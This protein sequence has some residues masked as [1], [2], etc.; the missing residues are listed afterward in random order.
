M[1]RLLQSLDAAWMHTIIGDRAN[2]SRHDLSSLIETHGFSPTPK[3]TQ[4]RYRLPCMTDC[5][6]HA[7]HCIVQD[8][9]AAFRHLVQG[10]VIGRKGAYTCRIMQD[11]HTAPPLLR[12]AQDS[13]QS[14]TIIVS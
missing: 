11:T 13:A 8:I 9:L 3:A 6:L 10:K 7:A 12:Y 4:L 1:S 2:V 5:T 14:H